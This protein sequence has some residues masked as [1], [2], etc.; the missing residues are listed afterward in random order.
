M[1]RILL[2]TVL[3]NLHRIS[4]FALVL[5]GSLG[6][7]AARARPAGTA[8]EVKTSQERPD[9]KADRSARHLARRAREAYYRG[10]LERALDLYA[11]ALRLK[12]TPSLLFN[13]AQIHRRMG[14]C[15]DARSLYERFRQVRPDAPNRDAVDRHI[16]RLDAEC[17]GAH[18]G[19]ASSSSASDP[20]HSMRA[21]KTSLEAASTAP[22]SPA[23]GSGEGEA[24]SAG[25]VRAAGQVGP[26]DGPG[27]IPSAGTED[28]VEAL[29]PQT[30]P[31]AAR[32]A[33]T[34]S[35]VDGQLESQPV[36]GPE[37]HAAAVTV[38][39]EVM[40]AFMRLGNL[41]APVAPS[42]RVSALLTLAESDRFALGA[43]LLVGFTPVPYRFDEA[44][45]LVILDGAPTVRVQ[46]TAI[47][48]WLDV[49]LAL[50]LGLTHFSG[51]KRDNPVTRAPGATSTA[52]ML[53]EAALSANLHL[54]DPLDLVI[55]PI[56]VAYNPGLAQLEPGVG[57][58]LRVHAG[59]GVATRF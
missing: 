47:D 49:N 59:L 58:V 23:V 3:R 15:A 52:L 40:A 9:T 55:H 54:I 44:G 46:W 8:K 34:P 11:Q 16:Q 39:A 18:G 13:L 30:D 4:L 43:G 35:S 37:A 21:F 5:A 17:P 26:N 10:D 25:D 51:L 57:G 29:S 56:S 24:N 53:S 28:R 14:H 41:D 27:D 12:E 38:A 22:S 1:L 48:A 50:S 42:I 45:T 31:S 19:G 6:S 36:A 7:T 33:S 2:R 32:T 20:A